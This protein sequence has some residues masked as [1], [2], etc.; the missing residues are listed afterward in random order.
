MWSIESKLLRGKLQAM[1]NKVVKRD[2][3]D[4]AKIFDNRTLEKDYGTLTPLLKEGLSVLDVGCGTGAITKDVALR[5]GP[6]GKITGIDNTERFILSGRETYGHVKNMQLIHVDLFEFQPAEQYD[7][8]ISA[9]T[10][11]WLSKVDEALEKM[12][13]LIKAG[14]RIS[15]L[16]YNHTTI[17]WQPAPP[18]SMRKFYD[19]FL[20]W[21]ADA[22]MNNQIADDLTS[23]LQQAGF[24]NIEQLNSDEHYK[25]GDTDFYIHLG[26]WS[27]VAGSRQMVEEGYLTDVLRLQAIAEYNQWIEREAVSMTLK[28][29]EVRGRV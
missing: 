19:I 2:G 27:K 23:L 24:K 18:E 16:D 3:Q 4:A 10:L 21:R 11:Q 29:N 13:S 8:I 15:I 1:E 25:K 17:D 6:S 7:L 12:K 26:I 28:L 20:K 5:I 9:R 14:G 22:G